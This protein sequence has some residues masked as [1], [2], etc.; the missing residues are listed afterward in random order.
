M[1]TKKNLHCSFALALVFALGGA[2]GTL[3]PAGI[4]RAE[5]AVIPDSITMYTG[6]A[7]VQSAPGSLRRVAV[8]DGR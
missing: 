2:L 1:E 3:V 7:L 6:Q 8:G 4:A 5:S